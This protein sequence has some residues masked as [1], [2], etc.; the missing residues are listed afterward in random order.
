MVQHNVYEVSSFETFPGRLALINSDKVGNRIAV[1]YI[2]YSY[3][4]RSIN[5][6]N[7]FSDIIQDG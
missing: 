6:N 3:F 5:E 4:T 2:A 7:Y 1:Y